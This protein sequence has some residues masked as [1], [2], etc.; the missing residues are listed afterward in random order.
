MT[1]T[2]SR[3]VP[4]L[5]IAVLAGPALGQA[6]APAP[7]PAVERPKFTFQRFKEDWSVL[8]AM[9]ADERTDW[10]DAIKYVPLSDDG[11]TWASFGGHAR[12]RVE[13]WHNFGFGTEPPTSD[14]TFALWRIL[15]H[16]DVHF[17]KNLRVFVEGKAANSTDRELKGGKRGL[18]VDVLDLEQAFVDFGFDLGG[19]SK[20]VVRPGRQTYLFGKQRLVSPLPWANT[21][22]RWDGVTGIYTGGGWDVTGFWSQFVPVKKYEFN[23][24]DAQ[25]QF[26]GVYATGWIPNVDAIGLDLYF[27][28]LDKDDAITVNGTTGH[29][30]RYTLGGRL[31]GA[32]GES[33]FDYDF[34]GAYQFGEVGDGDVN[35][36]MIGSQLGFKAPELWAKPRFYV[37][38]DFGSGDK[39]AGGDVE[40]FNHLFPL[41][42]AYLGYIDTVG[43]QNI[44]DFNLGVNMKPAKKLGVGVAGHFFWRHRRED[45]L[46]DAGGT[47]VR[48]GLADS[49]REVGQEVDVTVTYQFDRHL[50]GLLGYSYFFAGPYIEET[51][52]SN[53]IQF[54]YAQLQYT[55]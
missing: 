27:L 34:E 1:S 24:P 17:G 38:F 41:G 22:R 46:Y 43:R 9:P 32:F 35:A 28:G 2:S 4:I 3:I 37:G 45:A 14:D 55:F 48:P 18:D 7:E 44:I 31:F 49:S 36:F 53:D 16:A 39:E 25:T 40:T 20:I 21:L 8:S 23:T 42:H 10:A 51:G 30:K 13:D 11:E 54:L 5:A 52:T 6:E 26:F 33:G 15:L 50:N 47:V 29:E 12:L 19:D